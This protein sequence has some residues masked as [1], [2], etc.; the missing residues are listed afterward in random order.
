VA[1][2]CRAWFLPSL[3]TTDAFWLGLLLGV[4]APLGDLCESIL[5]RS[6]GVR[7]SGSLIPGHGGIM[8]RID[9]LIF[10]TPAFYYYLLTIKTP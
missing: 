8:D 4:A 7:D 5:K 1:F 10:T 2:A 6:A 9:S 3:S